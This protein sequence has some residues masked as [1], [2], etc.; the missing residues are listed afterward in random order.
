MLDRSDTGRNPRAKLLITGF[1]PFPGFAENPSGIVVQRIADEGWAPDGATL[2]TDIIPVR[3]AGAPEAMAERVKA[4]GC[5]GVLM[6]GV[7]GKAK[8]FRVEMRAQN[9]VGRSRKDAEGKAWSGE[10]ILP[11][12]PAVARATAPVAD[13]VRAIQRAGYPAEASS[14]AGDY[15][16]NFTLYRLLVETAAWAWTPAAGFLHVP[17]KIVREGKDAPLELDDIERAVKAAA[18]AYALK[19][20]PAQPELASA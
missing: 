2:E 15:L 10:K 8:T 5:D 11:V 9:R 13:M 6:I 12:G 3:W 7:A 14:D 19:L 18:S 20:I 17:T 1:G 4:S 16:C